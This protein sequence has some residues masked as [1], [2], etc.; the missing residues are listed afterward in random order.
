MADTGRYPGSAT[1]CAEVDAAKISVE[2]TDGS[3][4]L[5]GTVRTW[6]EHDDAIDAAWAAPG[7][8]AVEND[9][10]VEV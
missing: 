4:T 3:V 5:R 1:A 10:A 6:A 8:T 2:S 9:L 7:V